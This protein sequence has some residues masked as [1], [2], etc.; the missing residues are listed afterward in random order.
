MVSDIPVGDGKIANLFHSVSIKMSCPNN[1][2]ITSRSIMSQSSNAP[3]LECGM[4]KWSDEE[5]NEKVV[6][7]HLNERQL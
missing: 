2:P 1:N 6:I 5:A 7:E 3:G 4:E